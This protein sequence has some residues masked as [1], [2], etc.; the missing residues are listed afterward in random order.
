MSSDAR[1]T[2]N[3]RLKAEHD[4]IDRF[5]RLLSQHHEAIVSTNVAGVDFLE[6]A[7]DFMSTYADRCHHAKE[8][9]L[10]DALGGKRLTVEEK[11]QLGVLAREHAEW[12]KKVVALN[13]SVRRYAGGDTRVLKSIV[14][15]IEA[16]AAFLPDHSRREDGLLGRVLDH[17]TP[18]E[19]AELVDRFCEHD[20]KL[21][22][23][24]YASSVKLW[25]DREL[26]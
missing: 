6:A 24:L 17:L 2:L 22:H 21:I 23:D 5:A 26:E 20:R 4:L 9:M 11:D 13:R 8:M 12:E 25:E 18:A 14:S 19:T 3:R 15:S 16:L 10:F 7:A 1:Q